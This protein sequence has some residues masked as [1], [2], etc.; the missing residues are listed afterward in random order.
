MSV[1]SPKSALILMA[2][3]SIPCLIYFAPPYFEVGLLAIG[4]LLFTKPLVS[5][6]TQVV[7]DRQKERMRRELSESF[8]A[9]VQDAFVA[10]QL[11]REEE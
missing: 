8:H 9:S 4:L 6:T 10:H 2:G 3:V 5:L 11:L 7:L 1:D